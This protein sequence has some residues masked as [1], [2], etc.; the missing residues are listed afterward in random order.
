MT[1]PFDDEERAFADVDMD[2]LP[3]EMIKFHRVYMNHALKLADARKAHASAENAL[4]LKEA[5]FSLAMRRDPKGYGLPEGSRGGVTE[6]T[7]KSGVALHPEVRIAKNAV[8]EARHDLDVFIGA[9][10]A[11]DGKKRM[12]ENL[13]VLHQAGF[14]AEPRVKGL[15]EREKMNDAQRKRAFGNG[16]KRESAKE[17]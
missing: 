6:E 10:G 2:E 8:V 16:R 5:E 4:E 15:E 9:I 13:V 3:E 12:L 14:H 11:L 7:I 1:E 17:K